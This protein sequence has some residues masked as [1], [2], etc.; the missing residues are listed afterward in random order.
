MGGDYGVRNGVGAVP[1]AGLPEADYAGHYVVW[2][3]P[4]AGVR[5][6]G[7]AAHPGAGTQTGVSCAGWADRRNPGRSVSAS[8]AAAGA[9]EER[10][11]DRARDERAGVR[12]ADDRVGVCGVCGDAEIAESEAGGFG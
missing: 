4:D 8:A 9:G 7:G 2:R 3:E 11:G 10:I 5:D 1:G 6:A 12:S